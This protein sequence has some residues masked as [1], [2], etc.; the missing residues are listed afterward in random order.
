MKFN[1]GNNNQNKKQTKF[2]EQLKKG[3]EN[4]SWKQKL[5]K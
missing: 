3:K 4:K 5:N 1:K 2:I